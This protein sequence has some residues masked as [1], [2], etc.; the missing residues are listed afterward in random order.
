MTAVIEKNQIANFCGEE[1][2]VDDR[3]DSTDDEMKRSLLGLKLRHEEFVHTFADD[4]QRIECDQNQR[5][6]DF[7]ELMLQGFD[8]FGGSHRRI[9]W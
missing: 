7:M 6:R 4:I 2:S 3:L 1:K 5:I 8:P 9:A